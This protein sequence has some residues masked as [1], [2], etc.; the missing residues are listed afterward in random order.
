MFKRTE[1]KILFPVITSGILFGLSFPPLTFSFLIFISL[2]ILIEIIYK[3]ENLKHLIFRSYSVFLISGLVAVSWIAVS[4][5]REGSDPFLI[6]GGLFV[7]LIYPVFFVIP[8][9]VIYLIKKN[10]NVNKQSIAL[11][12]FPFVWTG[13]EYFSSLS[14]I[15]FPW[16][17]AGNSQTYLLDKIQYAEYT[18]VFG[19]SFWICVISVIIYYLIS[20]VKNSKFKLISLRSFLFL[21]FIILIYFI[22]DLINSVSESKNKYTDF[23]SGE[24]I[25]IGIIQPNINPWKKWGGKQT[26]L[27]KGYADEIINIHRDNPDVEMVILPETAFPYYFRESIFEEKYRIIKNVSDSLDLPVLAGTPDLQ[28]YEDQN[29]A[30]TDAKIMRSSGIKYDTYNSAFLFEPG[31]EK[32]DLQKHYKVKLVSGSERMPYQELF[33]FTKNL[34]EWGVGLGSWQ[35]GKDTNLFVLKGKYKFNA[36]ICY[37]SVYPEFFSEFVRKGADFSVIITNDG[38]WGKLSGTYQHNQF[39]VFRSI[40]NRIWI[41]RCAN[42]GISEFIDPYGNMIKKTGIDTR[43][44]IVNE[45]GLRGSDTFYTLNGDL[46]ARICLYCGMI[47][48]GLSYVLRIKKV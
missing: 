34:M 40:E 43:V 22:P 7:V 5:M 36:A 20:A 24:K 3:T 38:W 1:R 39:A 33:P 31:K 48:L 45:I 9:A 23:S 26:E 8:S 27:M 21:T 28:I 30:P 10:L 2:A 37:E 15:S 25:K 41:A 29:S 46:F 16:L 35:I 19:V 6:A 42:T 11:F 17:L 18:G 47:I 4:G 13:F 44:N 32:E 12:A 14:Q